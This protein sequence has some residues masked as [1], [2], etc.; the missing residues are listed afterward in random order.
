VHF[1]YGPPGLP[2]RNRL[3][4]LANLAIDLAWLHIG[5]PT[6]AWR[7]RAKVIHAP[8]NWLPWWSPSRTVVTVQ[9]VAWERVPE[10]Y[11]A[12]F[13][14]YA[15]LFARRSVARADVVM[16][17]S[18]STADDLVEL[19]GVER[20]RIRVAPIGV[21]ADPDPPRQRDPIL[22]HVGEFEPRKHVLEL[23]AGHRRYAAAAPHDPP[24][25]RLVLAGMGGSQ[26]HQVRAA[27]GPECD[28]LGFVSAQELRELYRRATLLVFPSHYEGFGLP[29]AEALAHGCPVMVAENSSLLEVA[30]PS[31][32][33][34]ADSTPDGIASALGSALADRPQLAKRG[35]AGW[36]DVRSR[37]SWESAASLT[38]DAYRE[39]IA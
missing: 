8:V 29:I 19:Y 7:R 25:C 4:R 33:V 31:A 9:D 1:A 24:P 26:E 5:V 15:R 17:T 28:L 27:V 3:T 38:E 36:E 6:V 32:L 34:L 14:A 18:Q 11:P 23:I 10:S 21:E 13:R 22:L 2:R 30:G 39:A 35:R 12:F 16:T 20:N 37:L